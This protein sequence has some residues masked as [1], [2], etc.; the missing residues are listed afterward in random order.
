MFNILDFEI[1][2]DE[3]ERQYIW[4][5]GQYVKQ[6]KITWKELSPI[7]NEK[8]RDSEDEYRDE[9]AYRKPFQSA[10]N[11]YEDVFSK[12]MD[13]EY[14]KEINLQKRELEKA[15]I[16][17]RDERN[18]WNKQNY[19][20]ARVNQKLDYL[21]EQLTSIGNVNFQPHDNVEINSDNDILIILSD[22]HIG[23]CYLSAFGEYN[24]DIAKDRLNQLLNE[25]IKI[26]K[27]HSSE[28]CFVSLQGDVI[29][30]NIHNSIT[31]TNRENVIDQIKLASELISS[32][33]YELSKV[34]SKVYMTSVDGNH[35]R[36][37]RKDDA[38][39][40]ERLDNL[41]C[42]AVKNSLSYVD[43]FITL[44]QYIDTGISTMN[45]RGKTYI[46]V[47]GDYDSYTKS[48]VGN[49]AL[50]IGFIPYAITFGH[51]HTCAIDECNGIKM[52]RGGSLGG[53]GDSYTIE[54]RL[55]GK[56][57]QMICVCNNKGV[58]C[59]YPIELK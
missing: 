24:S 6:G 19:D 17:F 15:K 59:Y 47:H 54:K 20:S 43:N 58:E 13:D 22:L 27:R 2:N 3:N 32:F 39:H 35:S 26:A 42:W 21:E 57:S 45:I 7:I 1:H 16:Q 9:S 48:G 41:I 28:N 50:A 52:I 51:M 11:Y 37:S 14:A 44:N 46:G 18:A 29:S 33:C 38:L 10:E 34:F 5:V 8:W 49:L 31:V 25:T 36:I 12:M 30:G 56:P 23:A 55:T 53:C 40:D 4:R